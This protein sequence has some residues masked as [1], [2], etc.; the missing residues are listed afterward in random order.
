MAAI[1]LNGV[2]C[3]SMHIM[4]PK[5][6]P[7]CVDVEL[8]GAEA[9]P[10]G[11]VVV[12]VGNVELQGTIAPEAT[13]QFLIKTEARVIAGGGGWRKRVPQRGYHNDAGISVASVLSSTASA[14]GEVM[15]TNSTARLLQVDWT[16]IEGAAWQTLNLLAPEWY[17]DFD[18]LTHVGPRPGGAPAATAVLK[19]F[20]ARTG[21]ASFD[22]IEI[23]DLQVG[24]TVTDRLGTPRVVRALDFHFADTLEVGAWL[25]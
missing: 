5:V 15:G 24:M 1:A 9:A 22:V 8:D 7:W 18:G 3:K 4:V 16:R 10:S 11:A 20:N 17:V 14:C 21:H 13:G 6:G 23:T 25:V 2:R 12:Q 19:D